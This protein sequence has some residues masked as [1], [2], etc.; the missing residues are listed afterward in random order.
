FQSGSPT[1]QSDFAANLR[2]AIENGLARADA[3][4]ALTISPAEILGVADRLGTL[5]VGKIANLTITRGDLFDQNSRITHVF[6]D[7]RP[8]DLRPAQISEQGSG[9]SLTGAW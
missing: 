4:R 3:L 5:D 6:I 9:R 7:G 2:R 8:V 1:N